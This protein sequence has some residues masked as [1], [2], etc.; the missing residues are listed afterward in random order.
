MD[1]A[2]YQATGFSRAYYGTAWTVSETFSYTSAL[3]VVIE[4][5]RQRRWAAKLLAR[6]AIASP[7]TAEDMALRSA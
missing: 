7:R 2:I 4:H 3:D 5:Y 1:D 6:A